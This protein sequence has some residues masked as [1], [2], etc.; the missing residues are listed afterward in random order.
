MPKFVKNESVLLKAGSNS[1]TLIALDSLK[2]PF[3]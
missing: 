2:I 1:V 3:Y